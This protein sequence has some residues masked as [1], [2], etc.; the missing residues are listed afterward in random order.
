MRH[1]RARCQAAITK[2]Y[3]QSQ[4]SAAFFEDEG[5]R[6]PNRTVKN[7]GADADVAGLKACSTFSDEFRH[8][9]AQA[10]LSEMKIATA[11]APFL[12]GTERG[13]SNRG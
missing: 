10:G 5:K 13:V 2:N 4:F 1:W 3:E 9:S 11:R 8:T 7:V 12:R 6:V